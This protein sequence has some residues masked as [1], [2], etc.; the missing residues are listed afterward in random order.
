MNE[1]VRVTSIAR[2]ISRSWLWRLFGIFFWMNL[3]LLAVSLIGFCLGQEHAA[4][5][6]AW[7]LGIERSLDVPDIGQGRNLLATLS[8]ALKSIC[9]ADYIFCGANGQRHVVSLAGFFEYVKSVGI[10]L[11]VFEGLVLLGQMIFGPRRAR[12]LLRPLDKMA[13]AARALSQEPCYTG[14]AAAEMGDAKLHDLEDAIGRIN[15]DHPEQKLDMGDRDLQGLQD[16]VNSLLARMHQAYRQ[17]AQFVSDASHELRTPIAVIQGYA[18]MLDRWG[19]QDDKVLEESIAAIKSEADYM[20]HLVEQLLILARG[21]TGRSR[22]DF[23]NVL[24]DELVKEVYE[25]CQIIDKT[26]D[27]RI[28]VR[29]DVVCTGDL[30]A[31]KQCV[32]ILTDNAM[33]YTPQKGLI[34]LRAFEDT[35]G[36]PCVE[37]QDSGIGVSAEDAPRVFDRFYRSDPARTRESGGTGLGLSIARW[38][39]E[40]HGGSIDLLSRSG[41]GT[42]MT[43]R[44]PRPKETERA[45]QNE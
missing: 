17:Q 43:L 26:H 18:G 9:R 16:A 8:A 21:D 14:S 45:N 35:S 28:D 37:V 5:G 39:A 11:L 7:T 34:C 20:K 41:L 32:R 15:P 40:V 4:L 12:R 27:W 2:K 44:L 30:D 29:P 24:L 6:H 38:I 3:C 1:T 33:K 42:R 22:M 36:A 23:Q 10:F 31:L 13:R 19:K 25:D